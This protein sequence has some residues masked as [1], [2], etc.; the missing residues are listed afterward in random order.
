M[1]ITAELPQGRH[2][3][4]INLESNV[5]RGVNIVVGKIRKSVSVWSSGEN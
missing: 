5:E 2:E 4:R 3:Y 1:K